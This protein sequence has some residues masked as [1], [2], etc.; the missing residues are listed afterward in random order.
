[1]CTTFYVTIQYARNLRKL[2]QEMYKAS[3][4]NHM[5]YNYFNYGILTSKYGLHNTIHKPTNL[6][7]VTPKEKGNQTERIYFAW[8]APDFLLNHTIYPQSKKT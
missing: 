3:S 4:G 5:P 2:E 7:S 1:M 6:L 8:N